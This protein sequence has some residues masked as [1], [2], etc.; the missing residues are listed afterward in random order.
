MTMKMNHN[1]KF[2]PCSILLIHLWNK[3]ANIHVVPSK[4]ENTFNRMDMDHIRSFR[5]K[6]SSEMKLDE[7]KTARITLRRC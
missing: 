5:L 3:T 1:K 2:S 7:P 4:A 6:P